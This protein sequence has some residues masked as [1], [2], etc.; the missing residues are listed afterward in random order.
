MATI[1]LLTFPVVKLFLKDA[2]L[3][4]LEYAWLAVFGMK[5]DLGDWERGSASPRY[6]AQQSQESVYKGGIL[7]S[8]VA[9]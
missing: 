7:K 3:E 2:G 6:V 8:R 9:T 5:A 1:S 4:T